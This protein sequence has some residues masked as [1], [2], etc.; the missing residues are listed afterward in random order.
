MSNKQESNR[1][2]NFFSLL[3]SF[4]KITRSLFCNQWTFC[5]KFTRQSRMIYSTYDNNYNSIVCS[6]TFLLL[7]V[8]QW[9]LIVKSDLSS[10]FFLQQCLISFRIIFGNNLKTNNFC[11]QIVLLW[12]SS[13]NI[14]PWYIEQC[15]Q[16]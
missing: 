16:N 5:A 6:N 8:W 10:N 3:L 7:V 1:I 14:G 2:W 4:L 9:Q 12:S 13:T 15:Y 11:F